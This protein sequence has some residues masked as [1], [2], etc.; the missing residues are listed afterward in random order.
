MATKHPVTSRLDS[1]LGRAFKAYKGAFLTVLTFSLVTN[2]LA[3]VPSLY[4]LQ[5][6]DRVLASRNYGTLWAISAIALGLIALLA[7][8]E[9]VRSY[10]LVRVGNRIEHEVNERIFSATFAA[11]LRSA[12]GNPSQALN[13]FTNVRQFITGT[14]IAFFDLPW[15]PI[16][17]VVCFL[18]H[19][20]LGFVSLF[21]L[22]VSVT[23][24]IVSSRMTDPLLAQAQTS[25]IKAN[26]FANNNL[27]NAE[28]IEAM[29]MLGNIRRRWATH[30]GQLLIQQSEASDRAGV[31]TSISKNF[32]IAMQSVILGAGAYLV[33]EGSATPGTMI[34]ASILMG[35]ALG[36]VDQALASWKQVVQA[37]TAWDRLTQLLEAFPKHKDMLSL[38][39][40]QGV[41]SVENVVAAPPRR[42]ERSAQ[43]RELRRQSRRHRRRGRP[44]RLGQVHAGPGAGGHLALGG[45]QG[46]P[47]W[48]RHLRLEQA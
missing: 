29:G 35:K 43:G 12:G 3:L 20:V 4:M 39:A 45:W 14:G 31:L 47:G 8:L 7:A 25:A 26:V 1:E 40:P 15:A 11:T 34:A 28:V 22:I 9:W 38:P 48:R 33:I 36:P 32:R 44:Q 37:R 18:L 27:R 10:V 2:L 6:Y 30:N 13:D 46:S 42:P 21:G 24:A 5:I 16:Y 41:L 17:L 19:P 23:L